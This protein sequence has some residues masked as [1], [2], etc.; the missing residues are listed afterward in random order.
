MVVDKDLLKQNNFRIGIRWSKSVA[1]VERVVRWP[2][3]HSHV[4]EV[5]VLVPCWHGE[6]TIGAALDSIEN[7]EGLPDQLSVEIV[8]VADGRNEDG[9]VIQN[10]IDNRKSGLRWNVTLVKLH[11]NIGAGGARHTGYNY[12]RGKFLA[13]LDDDDVWHADKIAKQW[14]WHQGNPGQAISAHGYG[15]VRREAHVTLLDLLLGVAPL[16][17]PTLMINRLIW[18][19]KPEPYRYGEDWLM[20]AMAASWQPIKLLPWN[21]AKRNPEA[22]SLLSDKYSLSRQRLKLRTTKIISILRLVKRGRLNAVFI[23]ALVVLN[24]LLLVRRFA[25][26]IADSFLRDWR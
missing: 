14:N 25:L 8:V 4:P 13:F 12:C 21:L 2:G 9:L 19:H 22:P 15:E 23:P 3:I 6:K 17:T 26:D 16:P 5:S 11:K 10:W 1:L 7:Q 20:L 24:V 18:T